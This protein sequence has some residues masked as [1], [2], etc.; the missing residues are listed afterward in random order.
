MAEPNWDIANKVGIVFTIGGTLFTIATFILVGTVKSQLKKKIRIPEAHHTV[1]ELLPKF[2]KTLADWD[3]TRKQDALEI[4]HSIK[5]HLQNIRPSLNTLEKTSADK[6]IL[7]MNGRRYWLIKTEIDLDK[8]WQIHREL[9]TFV[10]L[11]D[12]LSRDNEAQ[13]L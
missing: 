9:H 6:V 10:A 7:L 12:G 4:I 8:C 3:D 1:K 5:G 2:R 11:L 13:R